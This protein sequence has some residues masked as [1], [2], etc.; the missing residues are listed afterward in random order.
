VPVRLIPSVSPLAV[1][2]SSATWATAEA[3]R[4]AAVIASDTSVGTR[5]PPPEAALE[6]TL[7]SCSGSQS[8]ALSATPGGAIAHS[9]NACSSSVVL[10]AR[11]GRQSRKLAPRGRAGASS[12]TLAAAQAWASRGSSGLAKSQASSSSSGIL[13][14]ARFGPP[15][16]R[17]AGSSFS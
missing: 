4:A 13:S 6:R 15:L 14:G 5:N 16:R 2:S 11:V 1:V 9:Q 17:T 3:A 12:F 8:L 7:Y 10:P